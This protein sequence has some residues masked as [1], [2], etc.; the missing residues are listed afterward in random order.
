MEDGTWFSIKNNENL[1]AMPEITPFQRRVYDAARKIPRGKVTTYK[2]LADSIHCGC[3]RAV[4]Q[5][6]RNNPFAPEVPCHRIVRS[7]LSIGGFSGQTDGP[8]IKQKIRMLREEGVRIEEGWV[9][10]DGQVFSF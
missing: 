2:R 6:L 5:A 1:L 8:K 10:G 9:L 4:G 3:P 7:D